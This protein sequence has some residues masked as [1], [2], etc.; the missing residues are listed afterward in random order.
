MGDI[1]LFRITGS[2][3]TVNLL[4][5]YYACEDS[6][7][8]SETARQ[9]NL[10]SHINH[11]VHD[12]ATLFKRLLSGISGGVLGSLALFD[13]L[14]GIYSQLHESPAS[15][16]SSQS[17]IRSK[18]IALAIGSI[19]SQ[20]R[21]E[22][23]CSVFGLLALV[24]RASEVT[25][26]TSASNLR[27]KF[28]P[29]WRKNGD[30][31]RYEA[32]AIIFG[33]LLVGNLLKDYTMKLTDPKDGLVVRSITPPMPK[34]EKTKRPKHEHELGLNIEKFHIANKVTKMLISNWKETVKHMRSLEMLKPNL[35][36]KRNHARPRHNKSLLHS[37]S[38]NFESRKQPN[39]NI[40]T[41]AIK[42]SDS[43][44]SPI[45]P[46]PTDFHGHCSY[47]ARAQT[48]GTT[49]LQHPPSHNHQKKMSFSALS[50]TIEE[51]DE[52]C[53]EFSHCKSQAIVPLHMKVNSQS[54][55]SLAS[56]QER[57]AHLG[58]RFTLPKKSRL[59]KPFSKQPQ[60]MQN[61]AKA[62]LASKIDRKRAL[63]QDATYDSSEVEWNKENFTKQYINFSNS[64]QVQTSVDHD[65]LKPKRAEKK[66]S[67]NH[68][69]YK[70]TVALP[71]VIITPR[72]I[73]GVIRE[74][75]SVK[76][77]AAMFEKA[78]QKPVASSSLL[79]RRVKSQG[80]L[81]NYQETR[82]NPINQSQAET[83]G[84]KILNIEPKPGWNMDSDT[85]QYTGCSRP[86]SVAYA[87]SR[88]ST[89][90]LSPGTTCSNSNLHEK[91]RML[92]REIKIKSEEAARLRKQIKKINEV[93]KRG[94]DD[95]V[96]QTKLLVTEWKERAE[97]SEQVVTL[98]HHFFFK[99]REASRP[100]Q[101]ETCEGQFAAECLK[102][103]REILCEMDTNNKMMIA[104]S[105]FSRAENQSQSDTNGSGLISGD[106]GGFTS[107]ECSADTVVISRG[108]SETSFG[109]W[110]Q[111]D[112]LLIPVEEIL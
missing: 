72:K 76:R 104:D 65:G 23:V 75:G 43:R 105:I 56:A 67:S 108:V 17:K 18:L 22:L 14:V 53:H 46:S 60:N 102:S 103:I 100:Y 92:Q 11:D 66:Y 6:G 24:G 101:T 80:D 13:V 97:K 49:L 99:L 90:D 27:A 91:I 68:L 36:R 94:L 83:P 51:L 10:P 106:L 98:F 20:F 7:H 29:E 62:V 30:L 86:P 9:P 26:G 64:C 59:Q 70:A 45:P 32:L 87:S 85:F 5:G 40:Q 111:G 38:A 15:A 48:S 69:S 88:I 84:R 57:E 8:V 78:S 28:D 33:P 58:L 63:C 96:E 54:T 39:W 74:V 19:E 79:S 52:Y 110:L 1:G 107:S 112:E 89:L 93:E 81:A 25:E 12:V 44:A 82:M 95:R 35:E 3:K 61:S 41:T 73:T 21:R 109:Q 47:I 55:V 4:Y 31:M 37:A 77:L 71:S 16:K 42:L 50:P 2:L 34:K